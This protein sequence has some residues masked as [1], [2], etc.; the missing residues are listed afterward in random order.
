MEP[1]AFVDE[2]GKIVL[3]T[4]VIIP[5]QNVLEYRSKSFTEKTKL[6]KIGAFW[7]TEAMSIALLT[8]RSF[9]NTINK[10]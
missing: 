5:I 7:C 4:G 8:F 2:D 10:N 6:K 1:I 9:T 3:K